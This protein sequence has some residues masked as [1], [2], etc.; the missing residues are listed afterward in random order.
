[1]TSPDCRPGQPPATTIERQ[2]PK[3]NSPGNVTWESGT[4][5]SYTTGSS[6]GYTASD[7]WK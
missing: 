2:Y 1:M 7:T 6:S 3:K 4:N 5:R